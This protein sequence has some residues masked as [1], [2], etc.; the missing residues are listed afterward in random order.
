MDKDGYL[1]NDYYDTSIPY[2]ENKYVIFGSRDW[3]TGEE[4]YA[5]DV[6]DFGDS[7][8][9]DFMAA[10][11][12]GHS[13][14]SLYGSGSGTVVSAGKSVFSIRMSSGPL[15]GRTITMNCH[16]HT[17]ASLYTGQG[18][19]YKYYSD[20]YVHFVTPGTC[21][22]A[23]NGLGLTGYQCAAAKVNPPKITLKLTKTNAL[24]SPR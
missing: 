12:C 22:G 1:P 14:A 9:S 8:E 5:S 24:C 15:S 4:L 18:G 23:M 7:E 13:G 11:N 21:T 6:I 20:G 2:F 3:Y 19:T 16:A 17:A 10:Y